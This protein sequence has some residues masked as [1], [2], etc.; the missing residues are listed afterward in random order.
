MK[1]NRLVLAAAVLGAQTVSPNLRADATSD[2]LDALK[3][4]IEQLSEKV[5]AIEKQA[6]AAKIQQAVAVPLNTNGLAVVAADPRV[7]QLDQKV[8]IL[9]RNRELDQ[10]TAAEKAKQ[11][12]RVSLGA[13]G[14]SVT[15][16]DSNFVFRVRGYVQADGRF[17]SSDRV[18]TTANDTF[19][20]RRARPILDGTVYEKFDYR[21]MLDLGAQASL[22]TANNA[23]LQDAYV[24]ARLW[25]EF[26][27][28]VGKFKEPVGLE[29][30][31]SGANMLFIERAYPTQ[32]VPNRDV[33]LQL[34]GDLLK[35]ALRYEA[36]VFNGVADGGSG[37][38]EASDN[39]KDFAG[40]LF[41]HPFKDTDVAALQG[42]GLGAAGTYGNYDGAL[43]P[44]FSEGLQKFFAYRSSTDTT[45]PN[46]LGDGQQYRIAPQAYYYWGPFGLLTEWVLSSQ[47]VKQAGGGAGAGDQKRLAH[48]GWQVAASYFLTGEENSYK[49]VTPKHP[50]SFSGGGWGAVELTA[51]VSQ[52][53]VDN[54]AF[55]IF[56]EDTKSATGALSYGVGVN[57]HLNRN[58]K[59]TLD[60]GHTDFEGAKGSVYQGKSEDVILTRA[61]FS[62]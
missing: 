45:K 47:E 22:S 62:F 27:I 41:A 6:A 1:F 59:L 30:L 48:T 38:F 53:D 35:G 11:T 17:Y 10:E 57:W 52:L 29:R 18:D 32:L 31:Q 58:L 20:I 4:Q 7:E 33:G 26:Q 36:G 56:A 60:Y 50:F 13:N 61:Q 42:L 21:V 3:K 28:Q 14:F 46:V 25:P 19:L 40:R 24:N 23:L 39:A 37:D 44:F 16:A 43:R 49:A 5:L 54:N 34:Q 55:P 12:P 2:Q 51:R 15:S 8:R 9:E